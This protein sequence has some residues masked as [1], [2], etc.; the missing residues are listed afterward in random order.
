MLTIEKKQWF[1]LNKLAYVLIVIMAILIGFSSI[2]WLLK[3]VIA[4]ILL[5]MFYVIFHHIKK[6]KIEKIT[7]N[8]DNQW[9]VQQQAETLSVVLKDY[10][11]LSNRLF[12]YLKGSKISLSIVLSRSIIGAEKF[13]QL[14]SKL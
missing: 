5:I 13:S 10:W 12:I 6:N 14:R 2:T 11:I 4:G 9:F 1:D 8:T 7:I 3:I